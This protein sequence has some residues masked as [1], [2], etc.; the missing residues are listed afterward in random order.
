[1]KAC[2]FY[3]QMGMSDRDWRYQINEGL[4][5]V[6]ALP[7]PTPLLPTGCD[8]HRRRSCQEERPA[9]PQA[10]RPQPLRHIGGCPQGLA[11]RLGWVGAQV[12]L[13]GQLAPGSVQLL[14][15]GSFL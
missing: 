8:D 5:A 15:L 9:Q 2:F 3:K 12:Q 10:P 6:R 1:M 4:L 7:R 14:C 11:V 13:A